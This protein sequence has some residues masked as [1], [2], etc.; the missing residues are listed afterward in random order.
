MATKKT[1]PKGN[2]MQALAPFVARAKEAQAKLNGRRA[3]LIAFNND[4]LAAVKAAGQTFVAGAKPLAE[5]AAGNARNQVQ[6][7]RDTAAS[8]KGVKSPIE[9][10]KLQVAANKAALAAAREDTKAFGQAFFKLAGES[11]APLK[12]RFTAV[13]KLAA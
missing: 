4:N 11:A 2:R 12:G 3:E 6:A 10:F 5:L 9:A 7:F 13:R 1:A 8:L